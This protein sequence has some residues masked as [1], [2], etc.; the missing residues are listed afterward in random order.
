MDEDPI[1]DIPVAPVVS[2]NEFLEITISQCLNDLEIRVDQQ[3]HCGRKQIAV[4]M[5]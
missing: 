5:N 4:D 1:D 3:N 2:S